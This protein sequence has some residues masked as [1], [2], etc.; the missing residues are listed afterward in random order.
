M[1]FFFL[2]FYFLDR[3]LLRLFIKQSFKRIKLLCASYFIICFFKSIFYILSLLVDLLRRTV[4]DLVVLKKELLLCYLDELKELF[5]IGGREYIRYLVLRV[6]YYMIDKVVENLEKLD[7][8][9]IILRILKSF[10]DW[11]HTWPTWS[12][13]Y[14]ELARSLYFVRR[15]LQQIYSKLVDGEDI[16]Y[17]DSAIFV[18]FLLFL[19]TVICLTFFISTIVQTIIEF[20]NLFVFLIFLTGFLI[21]K[22]V[23]LAVGFF[24]KLQKQYRRYRSRK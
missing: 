3:R 16:N 1:F 6:K 15:D 18:L 22:A 5:E 24:T 13:Y 8:E 4:F 19:F 20:F 10:S 9:G 17:V 14:N 21:Y 11:K 12:D 7:R 2:R 23:C